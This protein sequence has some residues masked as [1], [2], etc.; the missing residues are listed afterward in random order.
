M[1]VLG[2]EVC[3]KHQMN[4]RGYSGG[5]KRI[6]FLEYRKIILTIILRT[7]GIYCDVGVTCTFMNCCTDLQQFSTAG[8]VADGLCLSWVTLSL[9]IVINFQSPLQLHQK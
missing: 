7:L 5:E 6:Q 1:D 9:P 2:G 3:I 4:K 8:G